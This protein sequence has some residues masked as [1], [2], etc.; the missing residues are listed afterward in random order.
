MRNVA[1]NRLCVGV[2]KG[3]VRPV[4]RFLR[5]VHFELTKYFIMGEIIFQVLICNN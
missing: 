1:V 2:P 4:Y 5:D 3:E